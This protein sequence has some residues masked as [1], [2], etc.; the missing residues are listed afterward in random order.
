MPAR[1]HFRSAGHVLKTSITPGLCAP[2]HLNLIELIA[3]A[4]LTHGALQ[5]GEP[6]YP[7]DALTACGVEADR[8]NVWQ[9]VGKLRRRHGLVL[10][11]ELREP[12]EALS[13]RR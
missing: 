7:R 10:R 1:R 12:G 13:R 3:G 5:R 11:G 2:A 4:A 8:V 9:T 6:L